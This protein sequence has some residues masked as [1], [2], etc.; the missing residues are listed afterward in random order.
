MIRREL[1][2]YE[3]DVMDYTGLSIARFAHIRNRVKCGDCGHWFKAAKYLTKD[4]AQECKE[5]D[6]MD[7]TPQYGFVCGKCGRK[8]WT[9][10]DKKSTLATMIHPDFRKMSPRRWK[11]KSIKLMKQKECEEADK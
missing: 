5:N 6:V 8:Y 7:E 9:K 2:Q 4:I 11:I 1:N 10:A 3:N